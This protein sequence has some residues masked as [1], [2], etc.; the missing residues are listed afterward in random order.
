ME[1]LKTVAPETKTKVRNYSF[2]NRTLN[3]LTNFFSLLSDPTR[4]KILS[5]LSISKMCVSDLSSVLSLNQTT[6][7]HQ[8]KALKVGGIVDCSRQGKL[9]VY[10]ISDDAVERVLLC[11]VER[12]I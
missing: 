5:A 9:M 3:L 10:G 6:L 12:I 1:S 8:L 11:G 2:D 7:S 4:I